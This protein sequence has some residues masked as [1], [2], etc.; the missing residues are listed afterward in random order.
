M[1]V[2]RERDEKDNLERKL[3]DEQKV[4]GK[5]QVPHQNSFLRDFDKGVLL[6]HTKGRQTIATPI[7]NR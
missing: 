2:L 6:I 4:R 5:Y 1:D 7:K 3:R